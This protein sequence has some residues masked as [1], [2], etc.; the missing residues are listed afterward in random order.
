MNYRKIHITLIAIAASIVMSPAL[1][2]DKYCSDEAETHLVYFAPKANMT[3]DEQNSAK[4]ALEIIFRNLN[5]G[6]KLELFVASDSGVNRSFSSCFPGCPEEGMLSQFF[7]LGG[8]CKATLAKKHRL[9]FTNDYITN[10]KNI[11]DAAGSGSQGYKNILA[12]LNS[13]NSHG[14]T[15]SDL[16]SNTSLVSSMYVSNNVDK[17]ELDKFFVE[18]I[19]NNRLPDQFPNIKVSGLP[20]NADLINLWED[21]YKLRGQS[22]SYK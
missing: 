12:T 10:V 2:S 3:V 7:G 1:A 11:L 13:I 15:I 8:G 14:S 21:F 9:E 19:Q 17:D 5:V 22:F 20:I 4:T 18:A 16:T 6:D